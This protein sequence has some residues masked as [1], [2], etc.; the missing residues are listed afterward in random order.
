[1]K[2][3]EEQRENYIKRANRGSKLCFLI[4]LFVAVLEYL[5]SYHFPFS[6]CCS[7]Y[8]L[9]MRENYGKYWN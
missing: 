1:M 7:F 4:L 8:N 2:K 6:I 9:A 3:Y 5:S